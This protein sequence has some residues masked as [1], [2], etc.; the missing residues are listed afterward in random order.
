MR[1]LFIFLLFLNTSLF[2]QTKIYRGE[3]PNQN[4]LIYTISNQ[5]IVRNTNSLWGNDWLIIRGNKMYDAAYT[6]RCLYTIVGN[7]IYS[8]DSDSVFDLLYEFENGKLYQISNSALRK[9]LFT[10]SNNQIFIGDNSSVFE[11]VFSVELDENVN[12]A[13]LLLFLCL[14][15]Y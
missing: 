7:K 1:F 10:L 13:E 15:P 14:V 12:N 4:D 2:A 3:R 6:S 9:C 8:G 11:C 5:K